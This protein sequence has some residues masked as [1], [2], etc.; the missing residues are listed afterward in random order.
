M[1]IAA[2]IPAR[3]GS[4]RVKDKNLR[5][6]AGYSLIEI[7]VKKA[8]ASNVFNAIFPITDS[9]HYMDVFVNAGLESF[10]LRPE[11]TAFSESPDISWLNWWLDVVG[12]S[13][14]D[15]V[16]ILRPTSPFR[17]V[18]TIKEGIHLLE[19]H[20]NRAD[21]IRCIS[22]TSLHPGKMWT[23]IDG[24]INPL[25]PFLHDGTPWHSNQTKVLPK[26]YV[27]NAML[28]IIK[29]DTIIRSKSIS[30][31]VVVPLIKQGIETFDIN[32][33]EDLEYAEYLL[34]T[35]PNLIDW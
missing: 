5:K 17:A 23:E 2:V 35:R 14:F 11:E 30:G 28:E 10:P 7:A 34:K 32:Q 12:E 1:R 18:S 16:A 3:S 20:W 25:F 6:I 31:G 24:I 8:L 9:K 13:T 33:P 15:A 26:V 27:Q 29:I 19:Q 22:P 4:E 21:S